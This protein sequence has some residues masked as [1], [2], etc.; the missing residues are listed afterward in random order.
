MVER[1]GLYSGSP[2]SQFDSQTP[3]VEA[4]PHELQTVHPEQLNYPTK[5]TGEWKGPMQS[6]PWHGSAQR[7]T[8]EWEGPMQSEPWHGSA[9]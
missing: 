3:R 7:Q 6:E 5:E 2:Q 4:S 8:G 9:P 1:F